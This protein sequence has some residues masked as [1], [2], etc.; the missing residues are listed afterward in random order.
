MTDIFFQQA[1]IEERRQQYKAMMMSKNPKSYQLETRDEEGNWTFR[2]EHTS[3]VHL[4]RKGQQWLDGVT[5][6]GYRV[7]AK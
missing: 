4:D 2:M 7:R 5:C 1:D 6:K 3:V